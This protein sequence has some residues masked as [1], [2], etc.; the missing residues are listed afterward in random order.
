LAGAAQCDETANPVPVLPPK[1]KNTMTA[2]ADHD[3]IVTLYVNPR[4]KEFLN[5]E[6]ISKKGTDYLS[7]A[8]EH[9]VNYARLGPNQV[10]IS[11]NTSEIQNGTMQATKLCSVVQLEQGVGLVAVEVN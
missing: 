7:Y 10:R 11:E 6:S 2:A 4:R 9:S 3:L 1:P 8:I 5:L